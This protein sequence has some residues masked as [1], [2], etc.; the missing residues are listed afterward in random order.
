MRLVLLLPAAMLFT[1]VR[2]A[3]SEVIALKCGI[4]DI[5]GP[6][7]L[8]GQKSPMHLQIDTTKPSVTITRDFKPGNGPTKVEQYDNSRS[9]MET[10][11]VD[12]R[13]D[14]MAW[15]YWSRNYSY[16]STM[17]RTNGELVE[18]ETCGGCIVATATVIKYFCVR[19][20][21]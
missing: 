21:R 2:P 16:N 11:S 14:A 18:N 15:T 4:I 5:V 17:N 6:G 19:E 8:N 13:Q 1:G 12:I 9:A 10:K 3:S 7:P 20:A